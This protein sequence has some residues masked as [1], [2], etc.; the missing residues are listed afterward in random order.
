MDKQ[1]RGEYRVSITSN[2]TAKDVACRIM[3][4]ENF[5]IALIN[6]SVLDLRLPLPFLGT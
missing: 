5:L 1:A 3:R 4:R 2:V 6:H